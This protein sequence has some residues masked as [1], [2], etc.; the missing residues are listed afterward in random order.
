MASWCLG[1]I[2][3]FNFS[4]IS[5]Y[6]KLIEKLQVHKPFFPYLRVSCQHDIPALW[7]TLGYI[8]Y[9]QIH[10]F[11]NQNKAINLRAL[12]LIHYYHLTL[13]LHLCFAHYP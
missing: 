8:F 4:K 12:T 1:S 11:C 7:K 6:L 5:S 3:K 2:L 9:K 13:R 10:S